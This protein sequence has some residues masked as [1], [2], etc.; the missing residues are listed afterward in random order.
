MIKLLFASAAI[1]CGLSLAASQVEP[2][3]S[4]SPFILPMGVL[5]VL[6]AVGGRN[7][8]YA[9]LIAAAT[10]FGAQFGPLWVRIAV[11][12]IGAIIAIMVLGA[13]PSSEEGYTLAQEAASGK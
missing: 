7:A 1:G 3:A 2:I 5:A 12:T 6:L 10:T 8:N 13:K 4:S 9:A 11:A